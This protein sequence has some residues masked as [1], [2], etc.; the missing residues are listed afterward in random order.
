MLTAK[1]F[2]QHSSRMRTAGPQKM[3]RPSSRLSLFPQHN[4]WLMC[5]SGTGKLRHRLKLCPFR[6]SRWYASLTTTSPPPALLLSLQFSNFP[7]LS[8]LDDEKEY[9]TRREIHVGS[10]QEAGH[11]QWILT[12]ARFLSQFD[13]REKASMSGNED[14]LGFRGGLAGC[15]PD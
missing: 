6:E 7:G 4:V 13:Q 8:S 12:S 5:P 9:L 1:V 11:M 10:F 14:S 15:S 3:L 2:S